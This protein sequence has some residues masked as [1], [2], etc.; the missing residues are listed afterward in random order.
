VW[1]DLFEGLYRRFFGF[2]LYKNIGDS[3]TNSLLIQ[4]GIGDTDT[5][6]FADT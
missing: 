6:T 4:K 5:D 1:S 3:D 2:V